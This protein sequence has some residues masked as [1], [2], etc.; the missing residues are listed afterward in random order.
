MLPALETPTMTLTAPPHRAMP[1]DT[2]RVLPQT[3]KA[4][5]FPRYGSPDTLQVA[6]I[7]TPEP[8]DD[9]VVIRVLAA[10]VNAVDWHRMRGAPYFMRAT[11]GI[12]RPKEPRL[13]A[14]VAGRVEAVGANVTDLKPGDEV[15]GMSL[16]TFAEFVRV[17][18]DGVVLKPANLT[19]EQAG[20]V[21]VAATTALQGLR[22]KGGVKP[23]QRVLVIGAGGGV[24][25][26]AVQIAKAFGAHVTAV[27]S[28]RN[29]DLAR[30]IGADAAVDYGAGDFTRSG[31]R[32]ELIFDASGHHSLGALRRA[33]MPEG[34]LV[35]CGA[36]RGDWIGPLARVVRGAVMSWFGSRKLRPFLA[37]RTRE[38][39]I[40]LREL[41]EA[42][43]VTPV[44]DRTYPFSEIRDAMAYLETGQARGKVVVTF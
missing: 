8:I 39:L 25:T 36:G 41:I 20:A 40:A 17:A 6:E 30:S 31:A 14:D 37:H 23:G 10:S 7:E 3:M 38:D 18:A 34:T 11:D 2:S 4:I 44:I 24:G 27:T 19:F 12:R 42:G 26:Y 15:F 13:G 21:A 9:T 28:S 33:M 16:G 35:I 29:L 1:T 22:D 32:Y 43:S 5:V